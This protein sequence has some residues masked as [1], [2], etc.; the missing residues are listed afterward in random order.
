MQRKRSMEI[1]VNACNGTEPVCYVLLG[2]HH[3]FKTG[4]CVL[5]VAPLLGFCDEGSCFGASA[6]ERKCTDQLFRAKGCGRGRKRW[7]ERCFEFT[8]SGILI[9]LQTFKMWSSSSAGAAL[10]TSLSSP[11]VTPLFSL[12]LLPCSFQPPPLFRLPFL[13]LF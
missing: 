8:R 12:C 11:P 7:G 4:L 10:P 5:P 2:G 9:T 1:S 3:L 13:H 6:G